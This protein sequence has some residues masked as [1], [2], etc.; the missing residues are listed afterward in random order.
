MTPE[1]RKM[2]RH[3]LGLTEGRKQSYRN[4]YYV[5]LGS[6]DAAA[7]DDLVSKGLAVRG[8]DRERSVMFGLT[9]EGAEAALESG[10]TLDHE[11]FRR[12]H[13]TSAS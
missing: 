2:A 12:Q 8:S 6:P 4:R 13:D 1:Q 9:L 5:S 11:D 7:W 10:E 3:A